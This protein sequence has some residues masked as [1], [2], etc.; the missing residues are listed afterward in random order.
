MAARTN[1]EYDSK[2]QQLEDEIERLR[3][4]EDATFLQLRKNK[5]TDAA[6]M[7]KFENICDDIEQWINAVLADSLSHSGRFT[8]HRA[9][10]RKAKMT[11]VETLSRKM[12]L[13]PEIADAENLEYLF[14]SKE[15]MGFLSEEIFQQQ[16]PVGVWQ[17]QDLR[18][19]EKGMKRLGNGEYRHG[20]HRSSIQGSS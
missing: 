19:V 16:Y 12:S 7:Q 13:P 2:I 5:M 4:L 10:N 6:M 20:E 1:A 17:Y 18:T 15:I 8:K 11:M 9:Q 3:V 14:L